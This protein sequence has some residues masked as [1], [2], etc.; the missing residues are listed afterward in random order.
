MTV[1]FNRT[2][3]FTYDDVEQVYNDYIKADFPGFPESE[4]FVERL[5]ELGYTVNEAIDEL[6]N[7]WIDN[8]PQT[9]I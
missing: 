4:P 2:I 6:T 1:I 9:L 8:T 7:C 5:V 3:E